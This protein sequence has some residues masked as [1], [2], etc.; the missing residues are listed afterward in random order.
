ML[1]R[2]DAEERGCW[3]ERGREKMLKRED[4]EERG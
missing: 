1:K 3:R 4:G 2:E